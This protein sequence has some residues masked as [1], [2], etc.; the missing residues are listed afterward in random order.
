M[1]DEKRD[2]VQITVQRAWG[3]LM[4]NMGGTNL[5]RARDARKAADALNRLLGR[6]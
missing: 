1:A 6:R 4:T 2:P 5:Q 3:K